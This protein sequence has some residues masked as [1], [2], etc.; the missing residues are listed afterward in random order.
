MRSGAQSV[1]GMIVVGDSV[2]QVQSGLAAGAG[3]VVGVLS[4]AHSAEELHQAGADEVL[5][6]IEMLP[7]M[8]G[9]TPEE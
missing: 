2:T 6:S 1:D 9:V 8:L 3:L 4:G 5:T 7:A